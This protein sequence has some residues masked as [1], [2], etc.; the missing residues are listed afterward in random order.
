MSVVK[1]MSRENDKSELVR[2]PLVYSGVLILSAL[3]G[4]RESPEAIVALSALCVGDGLADP[5]GRRFGKD[6]LYEGS[7]KSW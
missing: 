5:I 1:S 4:W 6:K 3:I 7:K 2:G